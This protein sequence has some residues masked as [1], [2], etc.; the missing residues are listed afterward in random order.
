ALTLP[1]FPYTTLFRS[2]LVVDGGG[3]GVGREQERV[4]LLGAGGIRAHGGDE[5]Q[6]D[7][8]LLP[9]RLDA[10]DDEA[11]LQDDRHE[12]ADEGAEDRSEEHTSELQSQSNL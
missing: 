1:L 9:V 5:D 6:P 10:D 3:A 4:L 7:R 11:V 2:F 12:G 8:D